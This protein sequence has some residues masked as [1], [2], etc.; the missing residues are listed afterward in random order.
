MALTDINFQEGD[1]QNFV[2]ELPNVVYVG[3]LNDVLV[4]KE[5]SQFL[6]SEIPASSGGGNIFIIS[7]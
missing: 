4:E 2:L 1:L 3:V 7:E 5:G 6:L